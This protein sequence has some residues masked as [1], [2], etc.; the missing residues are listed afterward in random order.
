[1]VVNVFS[2]DIFII[3]GFYQQWVERI[4]LPAVGLTDS[5][6]S[7]LQNITHTFIRDYDICL[8]KAVGF[9]S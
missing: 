8:L 3:W 4:H 5:K 9:T 6:L 2:T 7:E 1:M